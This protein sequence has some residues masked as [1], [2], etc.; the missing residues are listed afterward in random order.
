LSLRGAGRALWLLALGATAV[1]CDTAPDWREVRPPGLR[2]QFALPCRPD[3]AARRLVLAGAEAELLLHA[4]RVAGTTYALAAADLG[5]ATR[6]GAALIQLSAAAK[7]NIVGR[8]VRDDP[9]VVAGMTPH[10]AARR[11]RIAGTLPDGAAVTEEV[12]VFAYGSR[13]YQATALAAHPDA[14]A[15]QAFFDALRVVP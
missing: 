7:A 5:D 10:P 14:A 2:L 1:G 6:V 11:Q 8:I 12:A 15:M 13:V 4:C 3:T 9:V